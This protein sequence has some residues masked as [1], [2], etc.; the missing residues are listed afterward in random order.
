MLES[1]PYLFALSLIFCLCLTSLSLC[2][3][4][5]LRLE[6][7]LRTCWEAL[8][9]RMAMRGPS[10]PLFFTLTSFSSLTWESVIR[11]PVV[12]FTFADALTRLLFTRFH[13]SPPLF[14]SETF[15]SARLADAQY[16]KVS[17]VLAAY[18]YNGAELSRGNHLRRRCF[19][20]IH[21][22]SSVYFSRRTLSLSGAH[23]GCNY[24]SAR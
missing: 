5:N 19:I 8:V 7:T 12:S 18:C 16:A 23:H 6:Q 24:D 20:A 2:E 10:P 4:S 1:F 11:H 21:W 13:P 15:S 22:T 17:V 9:E 3:N 14:V